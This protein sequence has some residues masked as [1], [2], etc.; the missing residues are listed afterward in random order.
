MAEYLTNTTDLTS[1]ANAIRT[2]GGTT[3]QLVYPSGFVSAINAIETGGGGRDEEAEA[4]L[5]SDVGTNFPATYKNTVA[6][7]IR[8]VCFNG[9]TKLVSVEFPAVTSVGVQSFQN[10]TSLKKAD[11]S[12]LTN[13]SVWAF[14]V[15]KALE[16]LIIRTNSVCTL[17]GINAFAN[18]SGIMAG[19][20]Y[21]YVPST[22][23]DS[24]KSA[25]NW[26]TYADQIRA[27]EDYPSITGG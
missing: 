4:A 5:I 26:S 20:G 27:I 19:T 1:V 18:N 15:C 2:K 17:A 9:Y 22:L 10:C 23:V 8:N 25:T 24:Y 7:K 16:A 14:N 13:I 6:T 12:V 3:A 21:I 11:F